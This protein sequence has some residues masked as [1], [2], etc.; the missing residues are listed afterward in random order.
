MNRHFLRETILVDAAFGESRLDILK[1]AEMSST[2]TTF[3]HTELRIVVFKIDFAEFLGGVG[4]I[5]FL[6]EA[7]GF[8]VSLLPL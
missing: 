1:F 7:E 6:L 4:K 2:V 3:A 5:I 8:G